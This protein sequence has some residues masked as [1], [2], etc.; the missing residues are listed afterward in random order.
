MANEAFTGR[1]LQQRLAGDADQTERAALDNGQANVDQGLYDEAVA[2]AMDDFRPDDGQ[3]DPEWALAD[4]QQDDAVGGLTEI[5][6]KRREILGQYYP[7][8]LSSTSLEYTRSDTLVYEFCL[9]TS[10]TREQDDP[11]L[12]RTF[13]QLATILAKRYLGPEGRSEHVGWPRQGRPRF[14][15][16]AEHLHQQSGEWYWQPEHGLPDDPEPRHSKDEGMDFAAWIRHL[17]DRPG[18]LFLLGQ[19]ACGD[20]WNSKLKDLQ[21]TRL[22]RWF[23]PMTYVPPVRAF[24]TPFHITDGLLTECSQQAGVLFDRIRL[25]LLAETAPGPIR[26]EIGALDLA[27]YLPNVG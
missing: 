4:R 24:C 26:N 2:D 25:T 10:T 19:C 21:P 15:K 1:R 22:G 9:V 6:E 20:N 5:L 12:A 8:R 23:G 7:F 11:R 18:Q 3:N 16:V 27:Q 14:R 17:D 13:E